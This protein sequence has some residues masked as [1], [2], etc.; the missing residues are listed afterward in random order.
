[1][2]CV[3]PCLHKLLIVVVV[4]YCCVSR[5]TLAEGYAAACGYE[6]HAFLSDRY[7]G[8]GGEVLCN[9]AAREL[10][11]EMVVPIR[12]AVAVFTESAYDT[13]IEA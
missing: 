5:I 6:A 2:L 12:F 9:V 7:A 4:T 11:L 1:M 8:I 13:D 3:E 10:S